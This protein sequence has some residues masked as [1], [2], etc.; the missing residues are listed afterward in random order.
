MAGVM[1]FADI[2]GPIQRRVAASICGKDCQPT[3]AK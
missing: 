1:Q 3:H 2:D